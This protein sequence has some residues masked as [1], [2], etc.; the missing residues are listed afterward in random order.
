MGAL[1]ICSMI[2]GGGDA[3]QNHGR[4]TLSQKFPL[5]GQGPL[6]LLW[7]ETVDVFMSLQVHT[8]VY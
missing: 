8:D 5:L 6:L 2:W 1:G 3:V 4:G 7:A